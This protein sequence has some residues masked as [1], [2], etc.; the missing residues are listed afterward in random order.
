MTTTIFNAN[1]PQTIKLWSNRT[2]YDF[3]SDTDLLG[4][5]IKYDVVRRLD[6]TSKLHGD[7]V[8]MSY[9]RRLS[10]QGLLGNEVATGN[11]VAQQYFTDDVSIDQLRN[12]VSI[13][14]PY[15]ISSQRVSYNLSEDT[16]KT[17]SD[18]QN[19]RAIVALLNQ[20]AGNTANTIT[21]DGE[22]YAGND[23]LKITGMNAAVAPSSG[24]IIRPAAL[25]TDQAVAADTT[26]TMKLDHIL[27]AEAQA[28]TQR[29]YIRPLTNNTLGNIKYVCIVHTGQWY[30]LLTDTSSAMQYRDFNLAMMTAGKSEGQIPDAIVVSKTLIMKTDK[31]P[32]GVNSSTGDAVA[33]CRRAVFMGM[34]AAGLAFGMG[35]SDGRDSVAG[36]VIKSDLTDVGQN[37]RVSMVGI[38]GMKK[39][40]FNSVDNGVIVISTYSTL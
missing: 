30:N 26:A 32:N 16:Y 40:T 29:P 14:A 12:V 28:E 10:N 35:Y 38:Y 1:D 18:W 2:M 25:T 27:L 6:D 15:T 7:R 39:V 8:R 21:Y 5:L 33:N 4:K 11:E 20:L 36:F 34:D 37:Y 3:V 13:P 31:I 23:R 19:Q 22:T 17:L 24:R 9:L